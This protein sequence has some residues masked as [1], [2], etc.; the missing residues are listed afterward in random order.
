MVGLL[1][2]LLLFWAYLALLSLG[3]QFIYGSARVLNLAHASFFVLGGYLASYFA[4]WM[5]L[6]ASI[7]V[8]AAAGAAAGAL[9]YFYIRWARD[10][11]T[12]LFLTYSLFW[13]MEALFRT[14]FGYGLYNTTTQALA[15]GSVAVADQQVPV[16]ELIGVLMI[17]TT[18]A[19]FYFLV[20]RTAFGMFLRAAVDRPDMAAAVGVP[21]EKVALLGIALGSAVAAFGGAV[22]SMWQNFSIGLAGTLLVYAFAAVAISGLGN[23]FGVLASSLI[24]SAIRSA[25]VYY[26]PELEIFAIYIAVLAVLAVRPQGLF[27]RYERRA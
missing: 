14:A 13:L 20:Y 8:A 15:L 11:T 9:F 19:L 5:P 24:I 6:A 2:S 17:L 18:M 10:E 3:L 21:V 7:A 27:V 4:N 16:A 26:F 12:Q 25:A 1:L 23:I 22:S